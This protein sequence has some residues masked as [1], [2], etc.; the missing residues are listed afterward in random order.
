MN[1]KAKCRPGKDLY[2]RGVKH[3]RHEVAVAPLIAPHEG[4]FHPPTSAPAAA[5]WGWVVV[6][7]AAPPTGVNPVAAPPPD[8]PAGVGTH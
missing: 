5:G 3:M 1:P 8:A 2:A 6:V 7:E 4:H